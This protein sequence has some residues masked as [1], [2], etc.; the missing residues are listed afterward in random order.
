MIFSHWLW[1]GLACGLMLSAVRVG[2]GQVQVRQVHGQAEPDAVE[3]HGVAAGAFNPKHWESGQLH[4]L[5][6]V[7]TPLLAPRLAGVFRNIYAPSAVEVPDGWRVFY[8]AWDGVPTGNDRIYSVFTRDFLD[9]A[10]RRTE[11]EHGVFVHVCNV[12]ALRLPDGRFHMVCTVYP[13]SKGLNKPAVF[14]SP[15]GTAWNGSPAPHPARAEDMIEMEGWEPYPAADINGMNVLLFEDGQYRLYYGSFTKPGHVHRA[16]SKDG[17]RFRYDGPSLASRHIVNDVKK[18]EPEGP[19]GRPVYLMGLHANRDGLWYALS[20]DGMQFGPERELGKNLG[21]SDRYIVALGWVTRGE[22]LLGFLYGAGA[23]PEL[24]RNRIFARWLQKKVVF[25]DAS[26]KR[27]EPAGA[28][29][30]DRQVIRL[31]SKGSIEGRLEVLGEDGRTP[32]GPPVAATLTPGGVYLL[33]L[34]EGRP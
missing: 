17:R 7:R 8:G 22:R 31:E 30:P 23:S 10:D 32:V 26:G 14:A 18:F 33:T 29:G 9:F 6:D 34:P 25:T 3:L 2:V 28:L 11:I 20:R 16:T 12:N 5:P 21:D 19:G 27:Y 15:D 4:V 24:N 1:R 13:D